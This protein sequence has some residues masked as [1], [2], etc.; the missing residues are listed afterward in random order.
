[1]V[2][3]GTEPGPIQTM[4]VLK[5]EPQA[6]IATFD[7][8]FAEG[9]D[10]VIVPAVHKSDDPA[11]LGWIRGQAAKGATIIG[12]CD[13]VWAVANAGL[14]TDH[15]A[16]GHWYSLN[17]LEHK[18][19]ATTWIRNSRYVADGSIVTT[20]GATASIPVSL[21]LVEAIAGSE[22]ATIVARELGV[23]DWSPVHDS[24]DFRLNTRYVLTAARNELFFWSHENVGIPVSPGVDEIA[25]ALVADAWSRT[26]RSQAFAVSNSQQPIA[27]KRGLVLIPDDAAGVSKRLQRSLPP[28]GSEPS[29]QALDWALTQ[30]ADSYG[31]ATAAFVALQMEYPQSGTDFAPRETDR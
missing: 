17:D 14:L 26:Y 27:T 13:G 2:A 5:I 25:L 7:A 18:F 8:R 4:P 24:N 3:V 30:I 19:P 9:A 29:A 10:Y 20:T 6:T 15:R 28:F 16:T 21:A 12:V 31:P 11:L 22:R 1:M 23:A